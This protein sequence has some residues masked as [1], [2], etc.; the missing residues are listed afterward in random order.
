M[1]FHAFLIY[2]LDIGLSGRSQIFPIV[3]IVVS[4]MALFIRPIWTHRGADLYYYLKLFIFDFG[5]LFTPRATYHPIL[6]KSKVVCLNI[7]NDDKKG[8]HFRYISEYYSSCSVDCPVV[9]SDAKV[10]WKFIWKTAFCWEKSKFY[11]GLI[12]KR[13]EYKNICPASL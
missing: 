1:L 4:D 5:I 6:E 12:Q 13:D 10:D 3:C 7:V 11:G 2:A 9:N 8:S